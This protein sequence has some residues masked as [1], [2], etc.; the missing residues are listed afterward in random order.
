MKMYISVNQFLFNLLNFPCNDFFIVSCFIARH[1]FTFNKFYFE[2]SFRSLPE[3]DGL[4]KET[5]ITSWMAKFDCIIKG[6]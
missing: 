6:S 5:V 2:L 4:S 1:I 3:I